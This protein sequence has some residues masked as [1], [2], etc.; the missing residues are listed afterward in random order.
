M[1]GGFILVIVS[2]F[3][4][5]SEISLFSLSKFQLRFLRDH[6]R[7]LHRKIKVL[8]GDPGGLLT[9]ILVGNEFLN[10]CFSTLIT[11]ILSKKEV[12]WRLGFIEL[13]EWLYE[14]FL[15]LFVTTPILLIF[16][17]I[18]PKIIALKMNQLTAIVTVTPL[19]TIYKIFLP[20]RIFLGKLS[21]AISSQFSVGH[22]DNPLQESEFLLMLEDGHREGSIQA[23]E[24]DLIKK[25]FELDHTAVTEAST[26]IS[27]VLSVHMNATV[28]SALSAIKNQR[29]SRIP[30]IGKNKKD[31]VGILFAKDLLRA[32]LHASAAQ[33]T[34]AEIMRKPFFVGSNTKFSQL[35]RKFK[36]HKTHMAIIKDPG[37]EAI[38][39]ITMSDLLEALLE[40]FSQVDVSLGKSS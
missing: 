28:T 3:L 15:G 31:V 22:Q 17:E 13:P 1:L 9:T 21:G 34:V 11:D 38:G 39:V 8:L 20:I 27:Q 23:S 29:Y 10:I 18:T 32:K 40:D 36:Q 33:V 14:T 24:M 26:P 5:A 7:P 4:A 16:C 30:V 2:A 6:F 12:T 35:F 25:V 37:K 19:Y